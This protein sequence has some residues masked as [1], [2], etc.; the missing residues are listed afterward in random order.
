MNDQQPTAA[1]AGDKFTKLILTVVATLIAAGVIALWQ[2][3]ANVARL[4]ERV[5]LWTRVF[6]TRFEDTARQVRELDRRIDRVELNSG[7]RER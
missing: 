4:E 7:V 1:A 3:T 5:G 6:E 2:M